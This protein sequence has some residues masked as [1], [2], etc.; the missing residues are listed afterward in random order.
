MASTHIEQHLSE[1]QQWPPKKSCSVLS[2]PRNTKAHSL[3]KWPALSISE[4]VH[5]ETTVNEV[6][7]GQ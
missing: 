6:S 3:A 4:F 7:I 1:A 5:T 2:T